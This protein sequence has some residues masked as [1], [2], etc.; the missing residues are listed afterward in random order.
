MNEKEYYE[1]DP[2]TTEKKTKHIER[3]NRYDL[4]SKNPLLVSRVGIGMILS[5]INIF[6]VSRT[7]DTELS[8]GIFRSTSSHVGI[9][10]QEK[11]QSYFAFERSSSLRSTGIGFHSI[12]NQHEKLALS[13]LP[14]SFF[15]YLSTVPF[16]SL[17]S[18][19]FYCTNTKYRNCTN[20]E[21]GV[22]IPLRC[23]HTLIGTPRPGS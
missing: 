5:A 16:S 6:V 1:E 15:A 22:V 3:R 17:C 20:Q 9:N 23:V 21:P 13:K 18:V 4:F 12:I 2:T 11:A 7:T 10:T 19:L 14:N 8:H